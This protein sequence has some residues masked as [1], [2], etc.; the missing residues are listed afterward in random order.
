MSVD[1]LSWNRRG[2]IEM[3]GMNEWM[4]EWNEYHNFEDT[5]AIKL[6]INLNKIKKLYSIVKF[7]RLQRC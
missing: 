1:E 4:N 5:K 3:A 6:L 2:A 7:D